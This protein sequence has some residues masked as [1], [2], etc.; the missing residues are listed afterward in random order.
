[1]ETN[2]AI[3]TARVLIEDKEWDEGPA[4]V[5]SRIKQIFV[6]WGVP[7][8]KPPAKKKGQ[9]NTRDR[10]PALY[11]PD[12]IRLKSRLSVQLAVVA[13]LGSD[14]GYGWGVS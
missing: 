14:R 12:K 11:I 13:G 5:N 1:M 3:E 6:E 10:I 7:E 2:R 8:D 9:E 4:A